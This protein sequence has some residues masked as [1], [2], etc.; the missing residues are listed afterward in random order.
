V[1]TNYFDE[2]K[3]TISPDYVTNHY[4]HY[5]AIIE[6]SN[7]NAAG[8]YFCGVYGVGML[9]QANSEQIDVGFEPGYTM[10]PTTTVPPPL[11]EL[12]ASTT[13]V[14]VDQFDLECTISH[15]WKEGEEFFILFAYSRYTLTG[16]PDW[17]LIGYYYVDRKFFPQI[18]L[19]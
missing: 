4:S 1:Y 15:E 13:A 9:Y 2:F 19:L 12:T 5:E 17:W 6:P 14:G 16:E 10:P 11:V 7:L 3:V 18:A 8:K